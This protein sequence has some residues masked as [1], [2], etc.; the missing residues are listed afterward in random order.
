MRDTRLRLFKLVDVSNGTG[1]GAIVLAFGFLAGKCFSAWYLLS[2]KLMI[3]FLFTNMGHKT[4][5]LVTHFAVS[6]YFV[7]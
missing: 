1:D 3:A 4:K 5:G 2:A 7:S 6:S